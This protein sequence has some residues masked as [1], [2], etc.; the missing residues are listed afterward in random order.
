MI[1][2]SNDFQMNTPLIRL[3]NTGGIG[4]ILLYPSGIW[5][6]NQTGG[7]SCFHPEVEGMFVPL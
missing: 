3:W 1:N 4:L 6:T 5:Y 2:K 7:Y